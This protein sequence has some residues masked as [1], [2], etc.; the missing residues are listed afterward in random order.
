MRDT[1][2][3]EL[4]TN[5]LRLAHAGDSRTECLPWFETGLHKG[6]DILTQMILQFCEEVPAFQSGGSHLAAPLS[7]CLV[8]GEHTFCQVEFCCR[9]RPVRYEGQ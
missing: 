9:V 2:L 4:G 3:G 7:D 1:D 5:N 8:E 6:V